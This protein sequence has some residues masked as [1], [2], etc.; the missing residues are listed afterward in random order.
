MATSGWVWLGVAAP[1]SGGEALSK[2]LSGA[3]EAAS[4]SHGNGVPGRRVRK[5]GAEIA[6]GAA[7]LA[8]GLDIGM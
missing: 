6:T 2:G 4:A 5:T 1:D 3:S 7:K 8:A